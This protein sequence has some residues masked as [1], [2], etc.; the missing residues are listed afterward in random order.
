MKHK[1]LILIAVIF[2]VA[3]L[4]IGCGCEK[5]EPAPNVDPVPEVV[6]KPTPVE[7]GNLP[8]DPKEFNEE[9]AI[10]LFQLSAGVEEFA[11]E[12]TS[13]N[14]KVV[15]KSNVWQKGDKIKVSSIVGGIDNVLIIDDNFTYIILDDKKEIIIMPENEDYEG[16]V[17]NASTPTGQVNTEAEDIKYLG[18]EEYAGLTTHVM[19]IKDDESTVKAW[20]HPVYGIPMKTEKDTD[21]GLLTLEITKLTVGQ[22]ADSEFEL[23]SGYTEVPMAESELQK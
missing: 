18:T 21:Q 6:E 4:A 10:K 1:K 9:D 2:L 20:L 7:E 12:M 3:A 13:T 22:V 15:S 19:E 5:E 23:P 8:E 14:N 16:T 17:D 11:Y